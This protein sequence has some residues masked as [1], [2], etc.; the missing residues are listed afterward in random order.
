MQEI[1]GKK[2]GF[3]YNNAG[4]VRAPLVYTRRGSNVVN[5]S[6][7]FQHSK[8]YRKSEMFPDREEIPKGGCQNHGY[9]FVG[10]RNKAYTG[11]V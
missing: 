2:R 9:V 4:G 3:A 6:N 11:I 10:C 5:Q 8:V 1:V 7:I